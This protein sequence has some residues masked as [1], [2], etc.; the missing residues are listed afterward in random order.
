[1]T[2]PSSRRALLGA[3]ALAMCGVATRPAQAIR[4]SDDR[5]RAIWI[6]N[7]ANEEVRAAYIRADGQVDW[8]VVA[9]L[10]HLF[11][12]LRR[13][14]EGPMPIL[15]LDMLGQIQSRWGAHQPLILLSGFRTAQTNNAL[16]GAARNSRHLEGQAAD[17]RMPGV[18]L[19]QVAAAAANISWRYDHLGIGTYPG[20]VHLDIGPRRGWRGGAGRS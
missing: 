14:Q 17:I 18:P 7:Q 11:R 10:K 8:Q 6:R 15:L 13:N 4:R 12:D 19:A 1:M 16:E 3:V 5:S 2:A 20:F 9:R